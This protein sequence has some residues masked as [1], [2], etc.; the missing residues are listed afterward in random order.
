MRKYQKSNK[1]RVMDVNKQIEEGKEYEAKVKIE[2][3]WNFLIIKETQAFG[4]N[5]QWNPAV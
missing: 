1:K 4:E 2:K 3:T 5:K